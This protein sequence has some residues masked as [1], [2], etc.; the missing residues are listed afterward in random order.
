MKKTLKKKN[1]EE[2]YEE[3]LCTVGTDY[4]HRLALGIRE[5]M[6]QYLERLCDVERYI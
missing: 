5:R 1:Y 4:Y 2:N 6:R 3:K